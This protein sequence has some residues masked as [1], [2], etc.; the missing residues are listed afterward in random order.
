[1]V[2]GFHGM[3][4]LSANIEDLLSDGKTPCERR[5]GERFKGPIIP[6]VAMVE[7]HIIS[8]KDLSRLHQFGKKVLQGVFLGHA[9]H[10][11]GNLERRH[12][13]KR[14]NAKEVL[15]PQNGEHFIFPVA[16]GTVK[17]SG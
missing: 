4:L 11:R 9:L 13:A 7:Y 12:H 2:G 1:M 6:F 5:F 10:A 14:L 3:L 16:D 17:L 8:A 15:T